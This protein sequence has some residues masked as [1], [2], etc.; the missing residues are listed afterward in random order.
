MGSLRMTDYC[1]NAV[2]Y[3]N[4]SADEENDGRYKC[5][6]DISLPE[7][8]VRRTREAFSGTGTKMKLFEFACYKIGH[9]TQ[10][11]KMQSF[12]F[13]VRTENVPYY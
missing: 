13:S 10:T 6:P 1:I 11:T 9:K 5:P 8:F 4:K 2:S 7:K 12:P 3:W